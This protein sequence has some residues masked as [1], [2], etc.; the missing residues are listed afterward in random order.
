M[1]P[2]KPE[3]LLK[4]YWHERLDSL[5]A[6][7]DLV[8]KAITAAR[9][10]GP[11]P[12]GVRGL[13]HP[14]VRVSV[15]MAGIMAL[16]GSGLFLMRS[17]APPGQFG[18]SHALAQRAAA[19]AVASRPALAQPGSP[20]TFVT[21]LT[22]SGP[23][24]LWAIDHAEGQWQ[25]WVRQG[26]NWQMRD[27][28]PGPARPKAALAFWHQ[29]GWLVAPTS[30]GGWT[31]RTTLDNGV[32]WTR[33]RLPSSLRAFS[34]VAIAPQPRS[35]SIAFSR[36]SPGQG[37]LLR[38]D[39]TG[40]NQ[41]AATNLPGEVL[42]LNLVGADGVL[43]AKPGLYRTRDGGRVW[44]PLMA[45]VNAARAVPVSK[46]RFGPT[47]QT[48]LTARLKGLTSSWG[49]Q[50]WVVMRGVLWVRGQTGWQRRGPIPKAIRPRSLAILNA[51]TAY[52]VSS[53]G[54]LWIT[55]D[56]GRQ[57]SPMHN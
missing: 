24:M 4:Q 6:P 19:G 48:L 35:L 1:K 30:S 15:V 23:G 25:V 28:V 45:T 11:P 16:A 51:K 22:R 49:N 33:L 50:S 46:V 18:G 53:L 10:S 9:R 14:A 42:A 52:L 12:H 13:R 3:R 20:L 7:P 57:W 34:T 32:R 47:A 17:K 41:V 56:G 44:S 2:D 39:G 40:F 36:P 38:Q 8:E 21:Q 27:Q 54:K 55:R 26:P 43:L 5:K 31:V 37:L 29:E